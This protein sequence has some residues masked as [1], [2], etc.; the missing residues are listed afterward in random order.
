MSIDIIKSGLLNQIARENI[1]SQNRSE[2]QTIYNTIDGHPS[3]SQFNNL[4]GVAGRVQNNS[5]FIHCTDML[6]ELLKFDM[7]DSFLGTL[8]DDA[9]GDNLGLIQSFKDLAN[10]ALAGMKGLTDGLDG[11][12]DALKGVI[13]IVK[14]AMDMLGNSSNPCLKVAAET[15]YRYMAPTDRAQVDSIRGISDP[16]ARN[17]YTNQYMKSTS[18]GRFV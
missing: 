14:T 9:F 17:N 5:N 11:I 6:K 15:S 4:G 10:S 2:M 18:I 7:F 3:S 16:Y 12:E 1:P 8:I 13:G